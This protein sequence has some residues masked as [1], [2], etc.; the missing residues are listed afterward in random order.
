MEQQQLYAVVYHHQYSPQGHRVYRTD[1][2]YLEEYPS[3]YTLIEDELTQQ[4]AESLCEE[5]NER[6][7]EMMLTL[8]YAS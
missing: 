6:E 1:D 8:M 7:W 5:L 2:R 3:M 4:A